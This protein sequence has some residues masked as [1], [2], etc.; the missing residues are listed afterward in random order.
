[1]NNAIFITGTDTGVGKTIFS[2]LL[3]QYFYAKGCAPFYLKPV[4]TG[5]LNPYDADSDALFVY[6]HVPELHEKDPADSVVYCFKNPKAPYFAARDEGATVDIEI[7][8]RAVARRHSASSPLILE[9]AGGLMVPV[10]DSLLMTD[11]I[12]ELRAAPVIVARAGLG[13][14]NH[15]SL[16]VEALRRRGIEPGGIV[17]MDAGEMPAGRDMVAENMEAVLRI[18]GITVCGVIRRISNFSNPGEECFKPIEEL[19]AFRSFFQ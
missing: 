19:S 5:C 3:M 10:T 1:V 8:R 11:L 4:Q 13:T 7:I 9:G 12:K 14:I 17:F 18:T 2:L 15:T 6:R 16:S